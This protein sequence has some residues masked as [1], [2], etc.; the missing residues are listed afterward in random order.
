MVAT[1]VIVVDGGMSQVLRTPLVLDQATDRMAR[2]KERRRIKR[3]NS[4]ERT[5]VVRQHLKRRRDR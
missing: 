5:E 4:K 1:A 3:R 2:R